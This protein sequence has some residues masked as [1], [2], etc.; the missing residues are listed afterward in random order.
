MPNEILTLWCLIDWTP[1][2]IAI[3]SAMLAIVIND[4]LIFLALVTDGDHGMELQMSLINEEGTLSM[5]SVRK[6]T[7]V[8]RQQALDSSS[9]E[10]DENSNETAL[11]NSFVPLPV[12]SLEVLQQWFEDHKDSPYPDKEEKEALAKE[13]GITPVQVI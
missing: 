1:F 10:D 13:S 3:K 12:K 7:V 4:G 6:E 8:D 9:S 11:S 5:P 2:L